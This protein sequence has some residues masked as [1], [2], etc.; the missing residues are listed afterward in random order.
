[1]TERRKPGRPR[2]YGQ[3]RINA[4]VRFTPE[5][6]A[7]LKAAADGV[8]RSISEE[9]EAR[10]ERSF[11]N[12]VLKEIQRGLKE[13]AHEQNEIAQE[14]LKKA[15]E[16][17]AELEKAQTLDEEAIERA[18]TRALAKARLTIGEEK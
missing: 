14:L 3:G 8:G 10:I 4:T 7:A 5:R 13:V 9:V 6:H 2:K 11:S 17:I 18:V 15:M 16:R 12:D 1:V